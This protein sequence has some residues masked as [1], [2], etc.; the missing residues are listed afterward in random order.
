MGRNKVNSAI[1][2]LRILYCIGSEGMS[3][4]TLGHSLNIDDR[5]SLESLVLNL[6][7][8]D[9]IDE[10]IKNGRHFYQISKNGRFFLERYL[11]LEKFSEGIVLKS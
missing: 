4:Y 8:N 10:S 3:L 11:I 5:D 9:C 2:V 7:Q 6:V 1:R